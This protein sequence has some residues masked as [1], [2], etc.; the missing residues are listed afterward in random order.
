MKSQPF[1]SRV[2]YSHPLPY[3]PNQ[4][5]YLSARESLARED[6]SCL[7]HTCITEFLLVDPRDKI[8]CIDYTDNTPAA[9]RPHIDY[10][11][12]QSTHTISYTDANLA[13]T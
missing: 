9:P 13:V 2:A 7:R 12:E 1:I 4:L 11:F 6:Q 5:L 3:R 10:V 8:K